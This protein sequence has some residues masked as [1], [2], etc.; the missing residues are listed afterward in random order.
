MPSVGN[1]CEMPH[2]VLR[3]YKG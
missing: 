3:M 1:I 2:T